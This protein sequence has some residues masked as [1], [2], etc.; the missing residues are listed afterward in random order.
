MSG[1]E[2]VCAFQSKIYS[3]QILICGEGCPAALLCAGDG[4]SWRTNQT[5]SSFAFLPLSAPPW[6]VCGLQAW[7]REHS[8]RS[9]Q[10]MT[11]VMAM[12]AA[13][14]KHH[15]GQSWPAGSTA[16]LIP[17]WLCGGAVVPPTD[18]SHGG[19][20]GARRLDLAQG[21]GLFSRDI[22]PGAEVSELAPR[23]YEGQSWGD[24]WKRKAQV[25]TWS[26]GG[27]QYGGWAWE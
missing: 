7:A 21:P 13:A 19:V 25:P 6:T 15:Q 9:L 1:L 10:T 23:D 22:S 24:S 4:A 26:A 16:K 17:T 8:Q 14:Y 3:L 2:I 27:A 11:T 18:T 5:G 20:L 12:T